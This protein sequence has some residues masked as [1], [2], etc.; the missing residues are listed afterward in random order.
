LPSTKEQDAFSSKIIHLQHTG[1]YCDQIIGSA[2]KTAGRVKGT[3]S[4]DPLY[5]NRLPLCS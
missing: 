2:S 4:F 3:E 5:I 1:F